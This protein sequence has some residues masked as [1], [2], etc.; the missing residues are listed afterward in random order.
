MKYCCVYMHLLHEMYQTLR[1]KHPFLQPDIN[2]V[3]TTATPAS[4]AQNR[5]PGHA[6]ISTTC[7]PPSLARANSAR[8]P[9]PGLAALWGIQEWS[10]LLCQV[11]GG[12]GQASTASCGPSRSLGFVY[13]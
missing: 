11:V 10:M 9:C 7:W 3:C 4:V 8:G 13:V 2:V 12:S 6:S 5:G 1:K